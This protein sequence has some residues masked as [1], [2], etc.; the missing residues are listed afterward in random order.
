MFAYFPLWYG[1]YQRPLIH[2]DVC[3]Q[4]QHDRAVRRRICSLCQIFEVNVESSN[5]CIAILVRIEDFLTDL[6]QRDLGALKNWP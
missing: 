6:G 2:G 4:H 3:R 1:V 5:F